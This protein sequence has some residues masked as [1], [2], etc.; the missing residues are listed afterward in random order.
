MAADGFHV[1]RAGMTQ[2]LLRGPEQPATAL[3]AYG[4]MVPGP[5]LRATRGEEV[6]ARLVNDLAEPTAVHWHG[7]RVPNAMDGVPHLTQPPVM[8]G[9]R[10]DYRFVARDAGTF[11]YRCRA[12]SLAGLERGLHGVVLVDEPIPPDVDRDLLLVLDA[13]PLKGD[14]TLDEANAAPSQP[15]VNGAPA[16]DIVVRAN[17]RLRIR[18]LNATPSQLLAIRIE[19]HEA[20]VMAIDGQPAEPFIAH[21]GRVAL[22]PGNRVDLFVDAALQAG[23]SASIMLQ[24][25]N[26]ESALVRLRYNAGPPARP[27][28]RAEPAP[29]PAN[30]L[31]A[32]M[33]FS[34]AYRMDV[35]LDEAAR[36]WKPSLQ[37]LSGDYGAPLFSVRRGGVAMLAFINA[38]ATSRVVHLHG[39]S[40]R[41]LDAMDDGWKPYWLDTLSVPPRRTARIAFVAD[42][43]GKWLIE[44]RTLDSTTAPMVAWFEVK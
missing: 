1:L 8:P 5:L 42:N 15:T 34:R 17:E 23:D 2:A 9:D 41:L 13:W 4:G 28:V 39:H 7:V 38:A 3:L 31:P 40:F 10:F 36:G 24:A 33:D 12:P 43:P 16:M 6:R 19:R 29:L 26:G 18:L 22:G 25:T 44:A 14:G 27:A 20:R 11:W 32:R 30:P 37:A 35:P 21:E